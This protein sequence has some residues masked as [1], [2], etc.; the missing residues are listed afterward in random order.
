MMFE[1]WDVSLT[2]KDIRFSHRFCM[3]MVVI[4]KRCWKAMA[5]MIGGMIPGWQFFV[6]EMPELIKLQ[7][8]GYRLVVYLQ[9]ELLRMIRNY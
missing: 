8:L 6:Y 5:Q 3:V 1:C 2:G 7:F 9:Q 4:R